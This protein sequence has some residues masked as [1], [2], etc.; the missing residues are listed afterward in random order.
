VIDNPPRAVSS[1]VVDTQKMFL[2]RLCKTKFS[3]GEAMFEAKIRA[4]PAQKCFPRN[5]FLWNTEKFLSKT[6]FFTK[7][8]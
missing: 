3:F 4:Q 7:N 2:T 6:D 5:K 1:I 8:V